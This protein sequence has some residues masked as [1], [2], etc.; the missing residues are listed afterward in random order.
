MTFDIPLPL[1]QEHEALHG[2]L[3]QATGA[4]GV[5]F[6]SGDRHVGAFYREPRSPYPFYELTSSGITH[7]WAAAAEAG[8]NRIGGLFTEPHFATV[9]IDWSARALQLNLRDQTGAARRSQSI[10]FSELKVSA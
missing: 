5:V 4:G 8:P 7:P 3:R 9:D 2:R 1:R 10:A 6:L